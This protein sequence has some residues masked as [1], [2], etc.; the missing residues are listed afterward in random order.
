MLSRTRASVRV[1]QP[2]PCAAPA[3]SQSS[4]TTDAQGS[5]ATLPHLGSLGLILQTPEIHAR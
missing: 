2:S 4:A 3:K 5:W 1:S